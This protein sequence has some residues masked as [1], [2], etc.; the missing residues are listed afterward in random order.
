MRIFSRKLS[1]LSRQSIRILKTASIAA[2]LL[3][4]GGCSS[5]PTAPPSTVSYALP[6]SDTGPLAELSKE[7]G[8]SMDADESAYWLIENS[9]EAL[10]TRLALLDSAVASLDIQYFIWEDDE[11]GRLLLRRL[12]HAA[13]RGV[14]IRLLMDDITVNGRD[15]EYRALDS[16]Q[17]IEVRLFNPWRLRSRAGRVVEFFGRFGTLN[18]RLHNK[19][20]IADGHLGIIGGRNI[21]NRYFG[22]YDEFVQNDLDI[23]FSGEMTREVIEDFDSYWNASE[24]FALSDYLKPKQKDP[25]VAEFEAFLDGYIAE[26]SHTLQSFPMRPVTWTEYLDELAGS[27]AAAPGEYL[28]DHPNVADT[29]PTQ[30]YDQLKAFLNRAEHEIVLSTAYF[31]PDREF[32][33]LLRSLRERGVRIVLLTN[34]L[35]TNNHTLAHVAYKRWRRST[36]EAG[37]ELFELRPDARL[38]GDYSVP[39]V[40][41]GFMGLHS[42]AAIVDRRWAFVGTPNLDPRALYLNTENGIVIDSVQMA[43]ELRTLLFNAMSPENAWH[44]ELDARGKVIWNGSEE[45]LTRQPA[46]GP[47]QRIVEFFINLLPLKKQA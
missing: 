30:L 33:D 18:H 42:K 25:S 22:L 7:I 1:G 41:P 39:P 15:H 32:V 8:A 16:H 14:R 3:C 21:G 26:S 24:S 19:T 10:N 2:A 45:V 35:Q 36:L 12:L 6:S 46:N 31:V 34:S 47:A 13:D 27:F 20:I 23:L 28:Y 4:L 38:L 29:L 44:L 17:N 40:E 37:I 9:A 43:E 11:S 5:L